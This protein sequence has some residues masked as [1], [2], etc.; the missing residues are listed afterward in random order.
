LAIEIYPRTPTPLRPH[1]ERDHISPDSTTLHHSDSL[2]LTLSAFGETFHL[3]LRPN[4]QLIHPSA[5]IVYYDTNADGKSVLSHTEPLLP[6][7][8]KAYWGDVVPAHASVDRMRADAAHAR[9]HVNDVLGWARITVHDQGDAS[10]GRPPMFEGAFS[11][12][13]VTHHVTSLDNYLR[14]RGALDPH[15]QLRLSASDVLDLDPDTDFYTESDRGLVIWRDSDVMDPWEEHAARTGIPVDY[16]RDRRSLMPAPE[17]MRCGHDALAWNTDPGLNPLLRR[18][19]TASWYDPF[20]LLGSKNSFAG[21]PSKRD[22]IAGS[23]A[24]TK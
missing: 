20:G 15:P 17:A 23:S 1:H 22:D 10:A 6:S 24:N 12:R 5:R 21:S 4:D 14:N 11:V 16:A 2:R 13:G 18:P 8:I 9:D 7:A 3:H 19:S